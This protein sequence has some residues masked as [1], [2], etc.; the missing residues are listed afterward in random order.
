M[1]KQTQEKIKKYMINR[2]NI[3]KCAICIYKHTEIG[4]EPCSICKNHDRWAFGGYSYC[5]YCGCPLT[6]SAWDTFFK[7]FENLGIN[8]ISN[9]E[10]EV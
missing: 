5:K 1:T 6:E 3:E 9:V 7:N 10:S 8:L 2:C 4:E